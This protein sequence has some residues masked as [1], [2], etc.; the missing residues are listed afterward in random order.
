MDGL[1]A[2]VTSVTGGQPLFAFETRRQPANLLQVVRMRRAKFDL[3]LTM[4]HSSRHQARRSGLIR[5]WTAVTLVTGVHPLEVSL[6]RQL[7][8]E[9]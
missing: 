2:L 8:S 6:Y 3:S 1:L 7:R 9:R 5:G 4:T